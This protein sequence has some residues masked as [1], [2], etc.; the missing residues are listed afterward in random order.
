VFG[1]IFFFR[2]FSTFILNSDIN[3][4]I[5]ALHALLGFCHDPTNGYG[6]YYPYSN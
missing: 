5:E 3:H 2:F 4:I 6:H 1:L